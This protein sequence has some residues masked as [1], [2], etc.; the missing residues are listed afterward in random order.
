M[1]TGN[2]V[3][4][5]H[6]FPARMA[7]SIATAEI[8]A[9]S[10]TPLTVLDPMVGS[11]TTAVL[12]RMAGH[13]VYGY[14]LDPLAVLL[15]RAWVTSGSADVVRGTAEQA[16]ASAKQTYPHIKARDGYPIGATEETKQFTRYWFD[17]TSRRQLRAIAEAIEGVPERHR[18]VLW[19]G[20]SR[21]II[22]KSRGVTLAMDLSHSRPH[23]VYTTAPARPLDEFLSSVEHVIGAAPFLYPSGARRGKM[24]APTI[25]CGDARA[26]PKR[27]GTVDL[28]V[29]SPPYLNAID[30]I[31]CSKFALVWMGHSIEELRATRSASVGAEVGL[32]TCDDEISEYVYERMSARRK[33]PVRWRHILARYV[34]DMTRVLREIHRVLRVSGRAVLVVGDSRVRGVFISNSRMIEEAAACV[35]LT[36]ESRDRRKLDAS[37][38]YLPPP[39]SQASSSIDTR[40]GYEVILRFKKAA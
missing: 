4:P 12:A 26:I 35:G 17:L 20:V 11:G 30:Y 15:S 13:R 32:R 31:R 28:V 10:K 27:S 22:A 34:D 9:T 24:P 37:R 39:K 14:D 23:K 1:N 2:P 33:L 18:D 8:G 6:P 3:R 25:A 16:A 36:L 5:I 40:M 7:P 19:A 38:R 21:M 29:T